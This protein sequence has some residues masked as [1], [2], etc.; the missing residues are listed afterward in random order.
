MGMAPISMV[1]L[2][3]GRSRRCSFIGRGV[4]LVVGFEVSEAQAISSLLLSLSTTC[5]SDVNAQQL[6]LQ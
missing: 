3:W 6:L 4:R 1:E 2:F 5:G